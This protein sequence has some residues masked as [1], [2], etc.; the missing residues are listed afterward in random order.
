L[1]LNLRFTGWHRYKATNTVSLVYQNGSLAAENLSGKRFEWLPTGRSLFRDKR[2]PR[3]NLNGL[4]IGR[5]GVSAVLYTLTGIGGPWA[6]DPPYYATVER[7]ETGP[8][9]DV[10]TTVIETWHGWTHRRSI[11]F[12]PNGPILVLDEAS[13]PSTSSAELVWHL[14]GGAHSSGQR[15]RLREGE[16]PA[17]VV[18]LPNKGEVHFN[19][20]ETGMHVQ[21]SGTGSLSLATVF[22]TN[23]W[24]GAEITATPNSITILGKRSVTIPLG[25]R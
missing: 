13:G 3:E 6:Q 20:N 19:L 9:M 22:L 16:S 5:T 25:E 18:F 2:V 17:E 12:V 21:V 14:P 11:Y 8:E 15:I 24:A 4:V 1:L 7:F 10:S 23:D